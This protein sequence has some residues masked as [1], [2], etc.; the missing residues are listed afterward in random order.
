MKTSDATLATRVSSLCV[1][2]SV[3]PYFALTFAISWAGALILVAPRL[4]RGESIPKFTGLMMFP[5]M[6]LGPAISGIALTAKSAGAPG[7]RA[8]F[9]RI[10]AP[11]SVRWLAVLLIPPGTIAIV[12]AIFTLAVSPAYTPNRFL[13]GASFGVIAGFVEEIGWTGFAFPAM[14]RNRSPLRA[15]T[16][17]GLLWSLWHLPVVD[18]LGAITPHG[19]S[20]AAYFLAFAAVMTAM[21]ALICWVYVNT[22]SLLLAQLLHASSTGSL[23]VLSPP[24]IT[25]AQES[26]WYFAYAGVLWVVVAAVVQINGMTLT[27]RMQPLEVEQ[28]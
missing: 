18:Y 1:S 12:L 27:R 25:A 8:L 4:L 19:A 23:V 13:I 28:V 14:Q 24:R 3:L 15:A 16:I 9:R 17:L 22:G 11:F 2:D 20:W 21:R 6:L 7:I 5:V 10:V 26:L